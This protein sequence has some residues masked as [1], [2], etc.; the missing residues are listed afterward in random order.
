M[1]TEYKG[2][3][4]EIPWARRLPSEYFRDHVWVSTQPLELTPDRHQV[5]ELLGWIGAEDWLVF[6]SDYPHWDS[7]ELEHLRGRLPK[8]WHDNV[9]CK[10]AMRLYDWLEADLPA[11]AAAGAAT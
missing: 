7:D 5:I 8:G 1:D 11:P 9:F 2:L 3:R 4:R 6:S 10:N